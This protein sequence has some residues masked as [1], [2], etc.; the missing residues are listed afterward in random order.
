[1]KKSLRSFCVIA[2]SS[3]ICYAGCSKSGSSPGNVAYTIENLSGTYEL[4][5]LSW[6]FGGLNVSV[7]DSLDDCEKDNLTQL[8]TDK[9]F[10][11]IDA[12]TVC[13]P[14]EDGDGTWDLKEDSLI[15]DTD[16]GRTKI[17]SFDGTILVLTG[18]PEGHTDVTATV[19]FKKK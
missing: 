5:G 7:Y 15:F 2:L 11:L 1:M 18:N 13:T 8:N 4:K 10:K 9:T 17:A 6:N 12:G 16:Y 3:A 19:T 14:P